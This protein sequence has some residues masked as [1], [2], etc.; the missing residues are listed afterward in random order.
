AK[1]ANNSEAKAA[2]DDASAASAG[3]SGASNTINTSFAA[4]A[5]ALSAG[6]QMTL[7]AQIKL[8]CDSVAIVF[9]VAAI[10][11]TSIQ[12]LA[13]AFSAMPAEILSPIELH[14]AFIQHCVD[15]G[16]TEAAL[17]VFSAFCQTFNT[18]TRDI[19]A[20]VQA[21]ELEEDAARRVL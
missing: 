19:H 17:A 18:A 9:D 13:D 3:A 6:R 11:A 7:F 15:S 14:A 5:L 20:I 10:H 21:Q 2:K 1:D 8:K 12:E 16:N 4:V